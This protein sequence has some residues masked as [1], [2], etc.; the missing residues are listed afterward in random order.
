MKILILNGPNLNLLGK[1]EPTIYGNTSFEAYFEQL[2]REFPAVELDYFQ[3]NSE[4]ILIDKLHEVGF[5]YS[6]IVFNAGAYTHTSIALGDAIA[7]IDTPVIEV[8]I[9]NTH[10]REEFRH[11]SKLAAHCQGVILGFGLKSYAL[12]LHAFQD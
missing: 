11:T 1:R 3:S 4:G 2:Q 9:S 5:T 10:A 6:G 8:H 12:A 7:A